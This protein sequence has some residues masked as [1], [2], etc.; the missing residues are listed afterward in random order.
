MMEAR[1]GR[2]GQRVQI[3]GGE[4]PAKGLLGP[5][6]A[7][8]WAEAEPKWAETVAAAGRR[9]ELQ[10]KNFYQELTYIKILIEKH[11]I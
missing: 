4:G 6:W 3:W 7:E 8:A 9:P 10:C 2:D 11:N 1:L 5:N